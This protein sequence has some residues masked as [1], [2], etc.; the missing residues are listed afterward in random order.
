MA[1]IS[2]ECI[3]L[4]VQ[5]DDTD[6]CWREYS[7]GE[8]SLPQPRDSTRVNCIGVLSASA[9]AEQ[10]FHEFVNSKVRYVQLHKYRELNQDFF[11]TKRTRV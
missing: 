4:L 9:T 8:S 10:K 5:T 1:T 6:L 3:Y 11:P 2:N 7:R